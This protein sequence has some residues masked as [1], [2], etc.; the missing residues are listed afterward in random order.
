MSLRCDQINH[1]QSRFQQKHASPTIFAELLTNLQTGTIIVPMTL[2]A[3]QI[4]QKNMLKTMQFAESK[5]ITARFLTFYTGD[6]KLYSL[7]CWN[8]TGNAGLTN[9]VMV[10]LYCMMQYR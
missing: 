5:K 9:S 8:V 1:T 4:Q 3:W 10:Y 7:N 2:E 6:T